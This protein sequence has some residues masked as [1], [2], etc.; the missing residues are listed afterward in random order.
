[1]IH[2]I[3]AFFLLTL[4]MLSFNISA[5]E[6]ISIDK[7]DDFYTEINSAGLEYAIH[8]ELQTYS[9]ESKQPPYAFIP[10]VDNSAECS[11]DFIQTSTSDNSLVQNHRFF[12][13]TGIGADSGGCLI[14]IRNSQTHE[15]LKIIN[16]SYYLQEL[17]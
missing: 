14:F 15:T 17:W 16:Y 3:S 8:F 4:M 7:N 13:S 5:E 9:F 1:M 10:W 6:W 2:K 12:I 11:V